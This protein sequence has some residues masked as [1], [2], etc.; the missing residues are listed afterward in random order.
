MPEEVTIRE[1]LQIIHVDSYGDVTAEDLLVSIEAVMRIHK[2]QGITRVFVDATK[3]TS[4]PSTF[5]SFDVGSKMAAAVRTIRIA[6]LGNPALAEDLR[7]IETVALN[8]GATIKV[9]YSR[10]A[11]LAWLTA[12]PNN[13]IEATPDGAPHG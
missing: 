9:F 1:D 10:E 8:R 13:S 6:V 4:L 2:E 5:P 11:A 7:F 3:E 12:K